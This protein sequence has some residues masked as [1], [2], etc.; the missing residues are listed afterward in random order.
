MQ[1]RDDG[2]YSLITLD[3]AS[4]TGPNWSTPMQRFGASERATPDGNDDD[5]LL[6]PSIVVVGNVDRNGPAATS[7]PE[8]RI[9]RF[10][11]KASNHYS[12]PLLPASPPDGDALL[13]G[14]HS[15]G[16]VM[17]SLNKVPVVAAFNF[18]NGI[19]KWITPALYPEGA[20]QLESVMADDS[21]IFEYLHDAHSR[22]MLADPGGNVLPLLPYDLAQLTASNGPS[23]WMLSTWFV[24]LHDQSIARVS[25]MPS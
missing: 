2:T 6:F 8:G 12:I 11:Q 5:E 23:Y 19:G 1:I 24:F 25:R 13:I 10:T 22:L 9:Y 16:F 7:Q 18:N 4:Y 3:S 15:N 21:L 14:E 17:G 20:V